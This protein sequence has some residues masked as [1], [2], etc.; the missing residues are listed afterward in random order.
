MTK[1][2]KKARVTQVLERPGLRRA[3][4]GV[5]TVRRLVEEGEEPTKIYH[6]VVE[7]AKSIPGVSAAAIYLPSG[8]QDDSQELYASMGPFTPEET[9][10]GEKGFSRA[11]Q[12]VATKHKKIV[13]GRHT[14]FH[15]ICVG[16]PIGSLIVMGDVPPKEDDSESLSMLARWT[17]VVFERQRLSGTVQHLLD[18]L[19][20]LNELNQLIASNV[21][22]GRI[23]KTLS[24]ESAFRFSADL[25][26]TLLCDDQKSS[27]EVKGIFGCAPNIAPKTLD[28]SK[29]IMGQALRLGGH[30]SISPLSSHPD[31]Q[32]VFLK[33]LDIKALDV[34]CLEVR[35][36]IL[37]VILLGY[38]REATISQKELTRFEEF[39]QAAAV[40]IGNSRT[41]ER[42]TS[43]SERLEELVEQRTADLAVQSARAEEANQ[44]K[45]RFLAN[46]SHEL[47]TPLTA[48]VGYSSVLGDGIFGPLNDKQADALQAVTRAS[49]HL[50][51]LI[52]DVLNLARIESGKEAPEPKRVPVKDILTQA[53][54]IILQTALSKGVAL[55]SLEIPEDVMSSAM[56]ADPKHLHQIVINV[57]GNAV[58]YTPKGGKV[59]ITGEVVVDKVKISVTDTGVGIPP[60]KLEKLFE[61]FERGDD[62][63]SKDQEG[64]GIGL[65]LTKHLVELNGGRISATSTAGEGSTFSVMMP[66]A[67]SEPLVVTKDDV[68]P[69]DIRL[70]G[71]TALVVD[72]NQDT[73]EVLLHIL[74]AAGATVRTEHS[75]RD[76]VAALSE[77]TPDIVLTDLAMPGESGLVLIEHMKNQL[78]DL[79][80]VPV[81]VL[82][83]CAFQSDEDAALEAGASVFIPKPFRPADVVKNVR[84][85]TL[86]SAMQG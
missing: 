68:S 82:S 35:G 6:A 17:G 73:C 25:S 28:G 81:I 44:A 37:G 30:L 79:S 52:D 54:K 16:T 4:A 67:S 86:R 13:S 57:L 66:L 22:L 34:C 36:E 45:S 46:M 56:W 63:Y 38:R 41:Q 85:L 29:G 27:L 42:I 80:R 7:A 26:L 9:I 5:E 32:L 55:Q 84:K 3:L 76:G 18:R 60:S 48:I 23:V 15:I 77:I 21:G 58:K 49:E 51:S 50:K 11:V 31:E 65:N 53:Y 8:N 14:Y 10:D 33:D 72:D 19:Q 78:S 71:L 12:A 20:V 61:R 39:C 74:K 75:V 2:P 24:R 83:A 43:Y 64:T 1:E 62:T 59:W 70:D 40:A 69:S 47:R